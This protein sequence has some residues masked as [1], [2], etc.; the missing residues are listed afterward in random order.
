MYFNTAP[1]ISCLITD[2]DLQIAKLSAKPKE[3]LTPL[4]REILVFVGTVVSA[5]AVFII[6]III[7]W[8]V[9]QCSYIKRS[10]S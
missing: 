10:D 1:S 7:A 8:Y 3:G 4:Q 9:L 2:H 6:I 5:M